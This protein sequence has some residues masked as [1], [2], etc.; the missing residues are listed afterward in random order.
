MRKSPRRRVVQYRQQGTPV[1][2]YVS[3]CAYTHLYMHG[4]VCIL[5]F[6]MSSGHP[7]FMNAHALT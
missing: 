7:G 1:Q 4:V 5:F 3:L 2:V 6:N